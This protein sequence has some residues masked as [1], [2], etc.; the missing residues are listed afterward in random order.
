MLQVDCDSYTRGYEQE[1]TQI[2]RR[3]GL[4]SPF[5][6][7]FLIQNTKLVTALGWTAALG[8]TRMGCWA[9]LHCMTI[10][11]AAAF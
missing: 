9:L 5:F 6:Y 1:T 7:A 8:C 4:L 2:K 10:L 3:G 11:Y